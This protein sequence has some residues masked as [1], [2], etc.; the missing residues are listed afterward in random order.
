MKRP[1]ELELR[2]GQSVEMGVAARVDNE[3][4]QELHSCI[5]N[6]TRH[7]LLSQCLLHQSKE[8]AFAIYLT[9]R[10]VFLLKEVENVGHTVCTYNKW[11]ICKN[12]SIQFIY[13]YIGQIDFI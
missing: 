9:T 11:K 5:L 3:W 8:R 6:F 7:L 2:K 4:R 13:K 10:K 1:R 12:V